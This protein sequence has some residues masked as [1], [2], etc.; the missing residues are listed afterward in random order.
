MFFFEKIFFRNTALW[1]NQG[2]LFFRKVLIALFTF[3]LSLICSNRAL[4]A[5]VIKLM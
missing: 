2:H 3:R 1:T 5:D 4:F